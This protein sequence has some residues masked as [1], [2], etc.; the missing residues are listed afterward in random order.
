MDLKMSA[1]KIVMVTG[2]VTAIMFTPT[3][4]RKQAGHATIDKLG[5]F[6]QYE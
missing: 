2:I 4:L 5:L 1:A 6:D 3:P